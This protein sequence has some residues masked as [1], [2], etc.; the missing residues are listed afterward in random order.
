VSKNAVIL[1]ASGSDQKGNVS[2]DN[3]STQQGLKTEGSTIVR[4]AEKE[5]PRVGQPK[6]EAAR[7]R[8]VSPEERERRTR[9]EDELKDARTWFD[10]LVP[11]QLRR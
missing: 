5:S 2:A 8:R 10:Y 4:F 3:A 9:M 1:A 6:V 7:A 11:R